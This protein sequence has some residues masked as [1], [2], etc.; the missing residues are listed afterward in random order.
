MQSQ[1]GLDSRAWYEKELSDFELDD[2][3]DK[4][5]EGD[6][7]DAETDDVQRGAN[8]RSTLLP[9]KTHHVTQRNAFPLVPLCQSM[10]QYFRRKVPE[11]PHFEDPLFWGHPHRAREVKPYV[12][13]PC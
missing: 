5:G 6:G 13:R 1:D 11:F 12:T 2:R 4:D 3:D 10:S 7:G 9:R 8:F